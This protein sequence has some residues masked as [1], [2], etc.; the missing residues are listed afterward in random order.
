M[1]P[2]TTLD[3]TGHNSQAFIRIV[4]SFT[5]LTSLQLLDLAVVI[6]HNHV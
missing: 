2:M 3:R 1:L 4:F 6:L 5:L